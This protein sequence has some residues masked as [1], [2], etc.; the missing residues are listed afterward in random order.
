VLCRN[1]LLG[2]SVLRQAHKHSVH[3]VGVLCNMLATSHLLGKVL[4]HELLSV[5]HQERPSMGLPSNNVAVSIV[6]DLFQDVV[7]LGGEQIFKLWPVFCG[8]GFHGS[9][10]Y[11]LERSTVKGACGSVAF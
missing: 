3:L 9:Q 7:E 5:L 1:Q 4:L 2:A 11:H 6:L 8:E 10:Q